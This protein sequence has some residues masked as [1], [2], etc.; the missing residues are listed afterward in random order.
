MLLRTHVAFTWG[1]LSLFALITGN[2]LTIAW[3]ILV[4]GTA[5][6]LIDKLGHEERVHGRRT[7]VAR[8]PRTHTPLKASLWG[9][10]ASIMISVIA[11]L[12][13]PGLLNTLI[14]TSMGPIA[15]LSH[16]LLDAFTEHGIYVRQGNHWKRWGI[17]HMRYDNPLGNGL[18]T[19][20]GIMLVV[21]V[22]AV[23]FHI[24]S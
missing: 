9:L 18:A 22:I 8:S 19:L 1:L 16:L 21:L 17:A 13:S 24:I 7:I 15:G 6:S 14:V 3:A 10:L 11:Y 20:T 5:N 12:T 4:S 2:E 23:L